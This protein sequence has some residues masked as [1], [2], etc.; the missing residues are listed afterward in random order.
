MA[1]QQP[2]ITN[3]EGGSGRKPRPADHSDATA[4]DKIAAQGVDQRLSTRDVHDQQ[5]LDRSKIDPMRSAVQLRIAALIMG[6][7]IAVVVWLLA[8]LIEWQTGVVLVMMKVRKAESS[9]GFMEV[10]L[11]FSWWKVALGLAVAG[12]ASGVVYLLGY[13]QL[14]AQNLL[15]DTSDVNQYA[16][17]QHIALPEE[18]VRTFDWFPDA[19][20][21]SSVSVSSMISHVMLH[22]KGLNPVQTTQR[23]DH[24]ELD[25]DGNVL[26]YAGEELYDEHD[27]PLL[28][29]EPM[30]DEA[31]GDDL[32][33]TSGVPGGREGKK[34]RRRFDTSVIP[35]NADGKNRDKL[36]RYP[37][38]A[39]MINADWELPDYEPQRPAGAYLVD[40]A[41]VNT[42]VLA[43]TRA[44][45]GQGVIE[46]TIDMW[47][48]E[49]NPQNMVLNDPKGEL[50][51]KNY[52]RF[53]RRGFQLVQFNLI[54]SMKTDIYN[55]LGLA[56]E[57]AREGDVVKCAQYVE[58]IAE[59]FFPLDGGDDPFWANSANNAF[60]RVAYGLIDF[61]MEQERELRNE[62]ELHNWPA[63]VLGQ[64]IDELWGKV[65][66]YTCYQFFVQ[67]TSKKRKNPLTL[68]KEDENSGKFTDRET[69]EHDTAAYE[70][71]RARAETE[72]ELWNGQPELDLLGLYFAATERLPQNA[73]RT[74][75]ANANNSLKSMGGAEKTIST[76]YGIAITAMSFFTDPTIMRLTSGTPSQNVD[77]GGLSFPRRLGVRFA[78]DYLERERLVG[79]QCFWSAYADDRF[80]TALGPDFDHSDTVSPEG[81][82]RYYFVGKFPEKTAYVKVELRNATTGM[83]VKEFR[84]RFE[85]DYQTSLDGRVYVTDPVTGEKIVRNGVLVE[86]CLLHT[87]DETSSK[88]TSWVPGHSWFEKR[89][90]TFDEATGEPKVTQQRSQALTQTMVRYS[91]K[92]RAVFLVTPPHLMKYAKLLL[93]LI[94]QLVDLNFDKSYMT[95]SNQKPLYKTRFMLD[96]LGNLQ[97]EGHGIAGFETML[98]IGLGQEQQFTLIMQTL[99]QLRD[100]YGESVDKIVQGNVSNIVFLKSTDDS[101]IETLEQMSGKR[102]VV[103]RDSK[104]V[105][106]DVENLISMTNVEGKVSYTMSVREEPVISYNDMAFIG[107]R[108]S[109]VFRA[110]DSPVWNRRETTLPMSWRLFRDTISVGRDFTLQTIP[111]LSTAGDYDPRRNQPDF[112]A[113][114]EHRK[115]Q[116][117]HS[118]QA[119][120]AYRKA[121]GYTEVEV[122]RLDPDVY[123]DTVMSLIDRRM[124]P[125]AVGSDASADDSTE[126]EAEH[127]RMLEEAEALNEPNT[128]LEQ[129]VAEAAQVQSERE[130][131]RYGLGLLSRE[132]VTPA[133]EQELSLAYGQ[134]AQRLWMDPRLKPGPEGGLLRAD[135]TVLIERVQ[136]DGTALEAAASSPASRVMAE[137]G[138]AAAAARLSWRLTDEFYAFL[139]SLDDWSSLAG[140]DFDREVAQLWRQREE[141]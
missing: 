120:E 61:H 81:W 74:L 78:P 94:K 76:V 126:R 89:V 26:V 114:L 87:T 90:L 100:V 80:E 82:A 135:G 85:K 49:K 11:T 108:Q 34:L 124:H 41:P 132:A 47:S 48:R 36:G 110:G 35:Y 51:V 28:K 127:K 75:I 125:A 64:R 116:A 122:A 7:V 71:A 8:V 20:A 86:L 119:Q 45:K 27:Q 128:D 83:L 55:P 1:K 140:G 117:L 14:Q 5:Q 3:V 118:A 141:A 95:K 123:S 16:G 22:N 19:G 70:E 102:H 106:K 6:T 17:D 37:T 72:A 103:Y 10:L 77:M 133:I 42:M 98:S 112:L 88:P 65:T 92:P 4:W 93:I 91:E 57:A 30:I 12:I 32:F 115:A 131:L 107:D 40:T 111:T 97:S 25:A 58:N 136:A 53:T 96:E 134:C 130:L 99:Q 66:L 69:G 105:T 9:V 50:L 138:A 67:L 18:I 54:N 56:A 46:P 21:H 52:V 24:D 101:M 129:A 13:R 137:P 139:R 68:L 113:M 15:N 33:E 2:R 38:V 63:K 39:E 73:I 84:F 43:M 31:F 104:T 44:G 79:T 60:K 121:F 109:I 23:S 29:T 59:V 62:A